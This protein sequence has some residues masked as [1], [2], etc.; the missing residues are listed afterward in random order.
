MAIDGLVEALAI[1]EGQTRLD[2]DA[3]V[4]DA[5]HLVRICGSL[6]EYDEYLDV[7]NLTHA[8]VKVRH[9]HS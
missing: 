4:N 1:F 9:L 8:T 7:V 2:H 3:T 5:L 6:V